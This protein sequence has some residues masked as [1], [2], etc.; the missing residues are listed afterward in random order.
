M[1]VFVSYLGV[2]NTHTVFSLVS[3]RISSERTKKL[4]DEE[5]VCVHTHTKKKKKEGYTPDS[6]MAAIVLG[7]KKAGEREREEEIEQASNR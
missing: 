6:R 1:S 2:V 5:C 4:D 3:H 7:L